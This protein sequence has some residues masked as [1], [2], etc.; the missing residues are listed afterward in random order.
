MRLVKEIYSVTAGFPEC[1]K[2]GLVS[3]MRR[4]SVSIPSNIAEGSAR[5]SDK[6]TLRFLDMASASCAEL[7]TQLIIAGE[8]NFVENNQ[9]LLGKVALVKKLIRGMMKYLKRK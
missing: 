3:Q 6:D 1:E 8:L 9:E 2:F 5:S 4:A 7:E